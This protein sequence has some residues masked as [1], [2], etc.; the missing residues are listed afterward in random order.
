MRTLIFGDVVA[1]PGRKAIAA[2]LPRWKAEYQPDLVIANA[3]NLAHG[4]GASVGTL[5]ELKKAGVDLFTSGNHIWDKNVIPL[6]EDPDG[7]VLRPANYPPM[8]PG[9]GIK[10]LTVAGQQVVVINLLG[11]VFFRESVDCPFRTADALLAD[12]KA[13]SP[14]PIILVDF[15]AEASS[16]KMALGRYLEGRVTAFWG[17]HTHIPT[18]DATIWP[19]RTAYLTDVGMTGLVDSIIGANKEAIIKMFL[20]QTPSRTMHDT[21]ENGPVS[22]NAMLL[23]LDDAGTPVSWRR[24]QEVVTV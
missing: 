5:E 19:G 8:N 1:K 20:S 17:T 9:R 15:H 12:L 4:A 23:E 10:Q 22:V 24:L 7:V 11:R 3:E 14:R 13:M 6:L 16:E 21:T 2:I 18:A